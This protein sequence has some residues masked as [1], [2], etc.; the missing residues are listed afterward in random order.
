MKV[1]GI[2]IGWT[3]LVSS[4]LTGPC[5]AASDY[6]FSY[7]FPAGFYAISATGELTLGDQDPASGGYP[8]LSI[9]GTRIVNGVSMQITGLTSYFGND[10]LIFYPGPPLLDFNGFS[11]TV[12]NNALSDDGF[13]D[14]NV[15][16]DFGSGQ[17]TEAAAGVVPGTFTVSPVSQAVVDS[18]PEPSAAMLMIGGLL[19]LVLGIRGRWHSAKAGIN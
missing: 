2:T 11:F 1:T 12:D 13:G 14:V 15:Y 3:L 19:S 9:A 7:S 6:T 4:A 16:L 10:D 8:I 5:L 17:Y 18:A